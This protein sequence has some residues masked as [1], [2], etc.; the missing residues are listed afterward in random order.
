M[1]T[2]DFSLWFHGIMNRK[3]APIFFCWLG[4]FNHLCTDTIGICRIWSVAMASTIPRKTSRAFRQSPNCTYAG[5]RCWNCVMIWKFTKYKVNAFLLALQ[6]S[7][8]P[9]HPSYGPEVGDGIWKWLIRWFRWKKRLKRCWLFVRNG[10][11]IFLTT[12][13]MPSKVRSLSF[14]N[15]WNLYE[16]TKSLF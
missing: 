16:N 3:K 9:W 6:F 5:H 4:H 13:K 12:W 15:N 8:P 10:S 14:G 2:E 1:K 7:Y 11:T